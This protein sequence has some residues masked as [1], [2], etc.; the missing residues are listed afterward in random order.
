MVWLPSEE[1]FHVL[2]FDSEVERF[3]TGLF[4]KFLFWQDRGNRLYSLFGEGNTPLC[5]EL[6][7]CTF[8]F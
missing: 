4:E 1:I 5:Y 8:S 2:L 7:T 6:F 3:Y